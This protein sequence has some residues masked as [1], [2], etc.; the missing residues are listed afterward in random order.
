MYYPLYFDSTMIILIPA[1]IL[2]MYAQ[3]KI[4]SA[5]SKFS[6]IRTA[7]GYTGCRQQDIYLTATVSA[8]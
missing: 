6:R 8:M 2:T 4:S 3:G 1:M 5:Y 7:S